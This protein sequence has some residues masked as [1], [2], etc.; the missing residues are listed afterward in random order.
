MSRWRAPATAFEISLGPIVAEREGRVYHRLR[1]TSPGRH[2]VRVWVGDAS[3]DKTLVATPDGPVSVERVA[4]ARPCMGRVGRARAALRGTARAH[5][6][7]ADRGGHHVAR[8][9]LVGA[10]VGRVG[11]G[12]AA[13]PSPA[14][15]LSSRRYRWSRLYVVSG[16]PRSGTSAHDAH[17]RGRGGPGGVGRRAN[18]RC[19]QPSG[20]LRVRTRQAASRRCRLA[21]GVSGQGGEGDF[22][23]PRPPAR[24]GGLPRRVHAPDD[25]RGSPVAGED[26][27]TS[28]GGGARPTPEK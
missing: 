10:L 24:Y 15:R 26:A 25:R 22:A 11:R 28:R 4:G 18:R 20:V 21:P 19:G 1:V 2:V 3:F 7:V 27:R 6:A 17:D 13:S 8:N 12:G 23:P 5:L 16:L 14:R 9:P